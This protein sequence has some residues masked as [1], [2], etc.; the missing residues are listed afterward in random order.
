MIDRSYV[1][2]NIPTVRDRAAKAGIR[3]GGFLIQA[4]R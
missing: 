2:I 3:L 4:L 1:Q